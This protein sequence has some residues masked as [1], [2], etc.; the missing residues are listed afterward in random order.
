MT[1]IV[2]TLYSQISERKLQKYVGTSVN[3]NGKVEGLWWEPTSAVFA[4]FIDSSL[5]SVEP[6]GRRGG[7]KNLKQNWCH[8]PSSPLPAHTVFALHSRDGWSWLIRSPSLFSL[9]GTAEVGAGEENDKA[10]PIIP[11][12]ESSVK[13]LQCW[14]SPAGV[15]TTGRSAALQPSSASA[16]DNS[17]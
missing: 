15:Q 6:D 13:R 4:T 5:C 11:T 14:S 16:F 10:S 8:S 7:E 9:L 1:K 2:S 3:V 12:N 17:Y